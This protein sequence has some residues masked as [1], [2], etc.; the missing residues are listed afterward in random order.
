MLARY[1]IAVALGPLALASGA[2]AQVVV[3]NT[4]TTPI[5]TS[6]VANGARTDVRIGEDGAIEL[7][8]GVA[9]TRDTDGD[10]ILEEGAVIQF[11]D[12]ADGATGIL[13]Q[14]G[15]T[16]ALTV[17]GVILITDTQ[18]GND[19]DDED[20]DPDGPFAVG[21]GRY[22]IR[23][24][25]SG[26]QTGD[27]TLEDTGSLSVEGNDSYGFSLETDLIGDIDLFSSVTV[28]GDDSF[29][30]R[31]QGDVSGSV[32]LSGSSVSAT[33]ENSVGVSTEGNIAGRLQIQSGISA[34]GFRYTTAPTSLL[35]LDPE[36]RDNV[37][38]DDDTLYLEDLDADD[39]LQ[40]GSALVVAGDVGGGIL[41]GST[42]TYAAG[43]GDDDDADRN[44]VDDGEEDDDG[45][46][47]R[48]ED[49]DDLDGD[50]ILDENE[51]TGSLT[52]YG[53]APAMVIGSTT[54]DVEIAV[55]GE[56]EAAYALI[57][58][59]SIASEGVYDGLA[60]TG[61]RIG[62]DG[63]LAVR[64]EGGLRND[65]SISANASEASS[66]AVRIGAG[67]TVPTLLSEGTISAASTTEGGDSAIGL[68]ID[69]GG[70]LPTLVNSGSIAGVVYGEAGDAV[71]VRDLS[72]T[73]T[74][75]ENSGTI[76]G[77][78]VATDDLNDLDDDNDDADDE[79]VTGR[80]IAI[81]LSA[82]TVGVTLVQAS[83]PSDRRLSDY[84]SDGVY[85]DEDEDDDN[86]G[87]PD[88]EDDDD[89]DDDNDGVYDFEE[90]L[91]SGEVLF[92]RGDDHLDVRNGS[93]I[94]DVSFGEGQD[95]LSLSGT[96]VLQGVLS[97]TDGR[98]DISVENASLD[99][100]QDTALEV[101][102]L[103]V[104]SGGELVVS[105]DPAAGTAGGFV[106]SGNA[107][108]A[109]TASVGV[110]L[111]SLAGDTSRF[112]LLSADSL[113]YGS[114]T[115]GLSGETAP[116]LVV[117]SF[118]AD[119]VANTLNVDVRRRTAD[120][121]ALSGVESSAYDAFYSA[122]SRDEDVRDAFLAI[123]SRDDFINL[124]EQTLPDHSGGTLQSLANGVDA[125][126]RA[127]AGRNA[128]LAPGEVSGW[129]QEINFYADKDK[130]E[131]YGFRAEGFGLAG[132]YERG[133][134]AGVVGA[135]F[136]IT[137]SDL[138][139]PESEAEEVL[140]A[141][142]IELGLYWRAQGR[143]WTAWSRA[144]AGY[145]QF[146][147]VRT[148]VDETIQ[149]ENEADWD[150]FSLSAAGGIA[151]EHRF[152]RLIVRPEA[153]AEVFALWEGAR[154]EDGGGDSFDLEVDAREGSLANA[155]ALLNLGYSFGQ[156][157]WIRPELRLGWKHT[158]SYDAG[159]TVA[160]YL[161]GGPGFV[162]ASDAITGGGPLLGF[163][164]NLGN[165]MGRLSVAG[166][167]QLLE[168]AVR[169]SLLLRASY[170]F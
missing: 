107:S 69:A 168:D 124:Y 84:D 78:V 153:Y 85:D 156:D 6:T 155:V 170:R 118:S 50:G 47:I 60:A 83:V 64:L 2:A 119:R 113:S 162:L 3:S 39:L 96:A 67:A 73:L 59:G 133:T 24:T 129:M 8:S 26:A 109:D 53:S 88:D 82:A 32:L 48:N 122:L 140:S 25:G 169:Y 105:I 103:T 98:L 101:S 46:G 62:V 22:A 114:A 141:T 49:D 110:R 134:G 77:V 108:F 63:G 121:M 23:I 87:I 144:A 43:G 74:R 130:T 100:R 111:T 127:L 167:A 115:G 117:A 154:R 12:A 56:G 71:G 19:D 35:D 89:N 16:G 149:V 55:V 15:R 20:G 54:R 146:S 11:E 125:V 135:S 13:L 94:G 51:A 44:G 65:G 10:V 5:V 116:Y 30:V 40:G 1:A 34:N 31:L 70:V 136:A 120:E 91:I 45:D 102:S 4:R 166:D 90:A 68:L 128:V 76:Y 145:A 14:G 137:S 143:G 151:Y 164:L 93:V 17:G 104:G 139:D 66:V 81:D 57:N 42:P 161:S 92:G 37:D 147:S 29:G 21:T 152:G 28:R 99:A 159:E 80:S 79:V 61:L 132:G 95:R 41:I 9:I 52:S 38:L 18:D 131:T 163:A 160:R 158:L 97:D 27:F 150:G 142:L 126:T 33:G 157:D 138:Q 165:G 106:V 58:E 123:E 36:D 75:I 148:L 72:G 7:G 86:D 112:T